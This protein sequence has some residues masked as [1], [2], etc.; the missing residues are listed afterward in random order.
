[1]GEITSGNGPASRVVFETIEQEIRQGVQRWFQELLVEE[2]DE[3]LG[4][5]QYERRGE[6]NGGYRLPRRCNLTRTARACSPDIGRTPKRY[7][8]FP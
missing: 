6:A 4:R 7:P 2:R 8:S 1:M 5:L 3:F